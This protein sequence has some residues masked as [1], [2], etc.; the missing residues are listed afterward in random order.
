VLAAV[1]P[2]LVRVAEY[3]R[4][5][6][7]ET[8]RALARKPRTA[9]DLPELLLEREI[10]D[11]L[12][13][14]DVI[15]LEPLYFDAIERQDKRLVRALEEAPLPMLQAETIQLG[16]QLQVQRAGADGELGILKADRAFTATLIA[17][18]LRELY[19]VSEG[20]IDFRDDPLVKAAGREGPV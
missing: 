10:R 7:Q 8:E 11:V 19:D 14:K 13:S 3:D 15:E 6:Q 17:T 4:R 18:A 2:W 12:R 9:A 1:K 16:R 5:M 20:A